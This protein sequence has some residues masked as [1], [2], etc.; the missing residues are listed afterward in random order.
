MHTF[1]HSCDRICMTFYILLGHFDLITCFW[2]FVVLS[3][4][5]G[6]LLGPMEFFLYVLIQET[7]PFTWIQLPCA[8]RWLLL[9]ASLSPDLPAHQLQRLTTKN[10]LIDTV[11]YHPPPP[12]SSTFTITITS[13]AKRMSSS[14]NQFLLLY[15]ISKE[16]PW[17]TAST[18]LPPLDST[19]SSQEPTHCSQVQSN[20]SSGWKGRDSGEVSP[21]DVPSCDRGRNRTHEHFLLVGGGWT[22]T[23][24]YVQDM[25]CLLRHHGHGTPMSHSTNSW[26]WP[27]G[28]CSLSPG[29]WGQ[30]QLPSRAV[31][32]KD[33][34]GSREVLLTPCHP[35]FRSLRTVLRCQA[36]R[37][38]P[39]LHPNH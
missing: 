6:S 1:L 21:E 8:Y 10:I 19:P 3:E 33:E 26:A 5:Q 35:S 32:S 13:Q 20:P 22:L 18:S 25:G 15:F 39:G 23:P 29:A 24:R 27:T 14:Q 34:L 30:L 36:H 9:A 17:S 11:H 38:N 37:Q 16:E 28:L 12:N 4:Q 2:H 7:Y 31:V